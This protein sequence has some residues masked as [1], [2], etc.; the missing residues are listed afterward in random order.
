MLPTDLCI[1]NL[2]FTCKNATEDE[3]ADFLELVGG[4]PTTAPYNPDNPKNPSTLP[5]GMPKHLVKISNWDAWYPDIN[6]EVRFI[7]WGWSFQVDETATMLG[8]PANLRPP[9]TFL[10]EGDVHTFSYKHDLWR[11]GSV[12]YSL[13]YQR[14]PFSFVCGSDCLFIG[15]LVSELGPLPPAWNAKWKEMMVGDRHAED[16]KS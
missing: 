11:A 3:D 14:Q 16:S 7:D 4:E 8:Q 2:A 9:E 6:E 13:F 1:A 10:F 12:L 5:P 15:V